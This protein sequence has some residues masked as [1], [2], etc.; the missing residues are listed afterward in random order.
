M[1]WNDGDNAAPT[2]IV[3]VSSSNEAGLP[4]SV[5]RTVTVWTPPWPAV[6][7]TTT[8]EAVGH[9]LT[10]PEGDWAAVL[11]TTWVEPAYLEPDA[12]WC[13]PGGEPVTALANGG[14]PPGREREV[15]E[16][17][18]LGEQ[19]AKGQRERARRQHRHAVRA[20]P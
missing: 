18:V 4:L 16:G 5:T 20:E 13:E 14:A 2:V 19:G 3:N 8:T 10:V 9:P 12:S 15:V 1:L 17:V 6:G 11:R 7:V